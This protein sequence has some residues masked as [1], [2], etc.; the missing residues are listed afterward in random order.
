MVDIDT[1]VERDM[2]RKAET[3]RRNGR[4][5]QGECAVCGR[6]CTSNVTSIELCT[7]HS[8]EDYRAMRE[9]MS[10]REV[11]AEEQYARHADMMGVR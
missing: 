6:P 8:I 4:G 1:A 11:R 10:A 5:Q 9:A 7:N 3:E 2:R